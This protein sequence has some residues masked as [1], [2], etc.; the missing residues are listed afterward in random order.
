MIYQKI[1]IG[2]WKMNNNLIQ[3][4]NFLK[5][6]L[7]KNY[8]KNNLFGLKLAIAPSYPFLFLIKKIIKNYP[9]EIFAQNIHYD[10]YGAY[11]GEVSANMLQSINI[12]NVILGHSE[13]RKYFHEN[14]NIL[15][16]KIY[17]ALNYNFKIIFCI[18]E[19]EEERQINKHF[20]IIKKQIESTI[21]KLNLNQIKNIIIAY[22]P[23]WAIGTGKY[24]TIENITTMNNY[25]KNIFFKK[26][27][28][29][30]S[31][32]LK[33]IYGGSINHL[34]CKKI[35]LQKNIDGVL[36]GNNSLDPDNFIKI[37]DNCLN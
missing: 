33:I 30:D 28:L 14:N 4:I 1:L 34:N 22:E 12:N 35:L 31:N 29:F 27:G 21:F 24:P 13:R 5:K 25:I 10:D 11:T 26:Y 15:L 18:G 19:N 9:L 7:K 8:T 16:K 20:D 23:I 37:I 17:Q 3:S 36:I 2:N 32:I 6:I